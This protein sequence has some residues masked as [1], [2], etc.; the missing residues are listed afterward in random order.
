MIPHIH[1]TSD[2]NNHMNHNKFNFCA[3]FC[4]IY[5]EI[6]KLPFLLKTA[7]DCFFLCQETCVSA[8]IRAS[9]CFAN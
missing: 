1:N 3:V 8:I 9:I 7:S 5:H 2:H 6:L 4:D